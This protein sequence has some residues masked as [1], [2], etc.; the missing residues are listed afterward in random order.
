MPPTNVAAVQPDS[1]PQLPLMR[2]PSADSLTLT[3]GR[4]LHAAQ[5]PGSAKNSSRNRGSADA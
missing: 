1:K 5:A 2:R 3:R 4:L